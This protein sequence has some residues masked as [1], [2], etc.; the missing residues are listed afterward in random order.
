M[1][2]CGLELKTCSGVVCLKIWNF[3]GQISSKL[4]AFSFAQQIFATEREMAWFERILFQ[5]IISLLKTDSEK[6]LLCISITKE[7]RK[8]SP[9]Q[10]SILLK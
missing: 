2:I 6:R 7:K 10:T 3:E 8:I 4:A 5:P 1:W 9:F